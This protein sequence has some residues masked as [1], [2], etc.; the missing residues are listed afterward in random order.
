MPRILIVDDSSLAR[1]STRKILE[2]AGHEVVEAE[3]GLRALERYYLERPSVVVLDVTMKD[4][5]GIEVL[6]RLRDMDDKAKVIIVTADVQ[7]STREMAESG[8]ACGF[9]IKPVVSR[10][11]LA[12]V[13]S[14][15]EEGAP[16]S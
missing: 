14:A 2:T 10:H 12:A 9:V 7:D 8:G 15:L 6:R 11:L 16:C 4:M 1:R 5:D 3:D 13:D